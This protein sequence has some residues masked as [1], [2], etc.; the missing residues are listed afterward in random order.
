MSKRKLK[1]QLGLAQIVMLGTA[2]CIGGE[3]FVLTGH[4]A[5]IAGLPRCWSSCWAGCWATA[6]P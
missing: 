1:R 3:I 4:V 2:G 5:G 6:S